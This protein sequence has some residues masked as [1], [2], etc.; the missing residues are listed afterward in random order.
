MSCQIAGLDT[1][2]Q[3][4]YPLTSAGVTDNYK[5]DTMR[6][7]IEYLPD[8][9]KKFVQYRDG[10]EFTENMELYQ[11]M[12][13]VL[14][15]KQ[16]SKHFYRIF[17]YVIQGMAWVNRK[18]YANR[19]DEELPSFD[20][21]RLFYGFAP[22]EPVLTTAYKPNNIPANIAQ[23]IKSAMFVQ[24][25]MDEGEEFSNSVEYRFL[26]DYKNSLL[27]SFFLNDTELGK[28]ALWG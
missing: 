26:E 3:I 9:L 10:K 25:Q 13:D 14:T 20:E 27:T 12:Q 6:I 18:A 23:A 11:M 15:Y 1:F 8:L 2:K 24:Y 16:Y 7:F 4:L 28:E 21:I 22:G 17:E 19:Y 5:M